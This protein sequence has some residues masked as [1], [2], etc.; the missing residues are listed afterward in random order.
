[1]LG[2]IDFATY[3]AQDPALAVV[4]ARGDFDGGD[5]FAPLMAQLINRPVAGSSLAMAVPSGSNSFDTM[6]EILTHFPSPATSP[7]AEFNLASLNWL[8]VLTEHTS[9]AAPQQSMMAT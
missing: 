8:D 2:L 3:L 7:A 1:M 4:V 6:S 9:G 5:Y